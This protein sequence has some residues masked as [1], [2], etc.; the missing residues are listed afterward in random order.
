MTPLPIGDTLGILGDGQ[1]GRMTADAAHRLGFRTHVFG[2]DAH[3]PACQVAGHTTIAPWDDTNALTRFANAVDIITLEFENVPVDTL[4]F[5]QTLRPVHPGAPVL[6]VCRNRLREKLTVQTAGIPTAPWAGIRAWDDLR[7]AASTIGF[8]AI[9]KTSELGYDGKGQARVHTLLE[10]E[11]AFTSFSGVECV[12]EGV[13]PFDCEIS[14]IT[15]RTASGEQRAFPV[16]RNDHRHHILHRS[17]VPAG[18]PAPVEALAQEHAARIADALGVIGL[19]AVEFFVE[20]GGL[21]RVNELAPRPHNS[22][23][24][25]MDGCQT[26]QFEQLV[27]AVTGLP[28]GDTNALFPTTMLNL[29]G[30]EIHDRDAWLARGARVH[31]YGKAEARAGRKMGHVNLLNP[32]GDVDP[33]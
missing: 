8:P 28:L 26:S 5:L 29:I 18:L 4:T 17:T 3:A 31:L 2:Q 21:L 24:W 9:L 1:L 10:L 27:R 22:G 32:V 25:T 14:V 16:A 11:Q 15:A 33:A 30:D 20:P 13:V 7:A 12:L 6:H 19:L 23:H